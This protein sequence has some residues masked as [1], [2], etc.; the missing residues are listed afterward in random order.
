MLYLWHF[1]FSFQPVLTNAFDNQNKDDDSK[2]DSPSSTPDSDS[3][4]EYIPPAGQKQTIAETKQK[5]R[6]G[7]EAARGRGRG[8][9]S[10]SRCGRGRSR[11]VPT[12]GRGRSRGK[13][14]ISGN[15]KKKNDNPFGWADMKKEN[16]HNPNADHIYCE[17]FCGRHDAYLC[18]LIKAANFGNCYFSDQS[19]LLVIKSELQNLRRCMTPQ[20]ACKAL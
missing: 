9:E 3:D 20:I 1:S 16:F 6:H 5:Q 10:T 2:L 11:G 7:R 13:G 17:N 19:L 4:P 18:Y 14:G 12:P 8:C 15:Q